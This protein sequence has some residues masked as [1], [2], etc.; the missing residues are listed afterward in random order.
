[1]TMKQQTLNYINSHTF[2]NAKRGLE[3]PSLTQT[4]RSSTVYETVTTT[5]A[6]FQPI[7]IIRVTTHYPQSHPKGWLCLLYTTLLRHYRS[8]LDI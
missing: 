4:S 5:T 7:G 2:V 6:L 3:T 1:M 8:F